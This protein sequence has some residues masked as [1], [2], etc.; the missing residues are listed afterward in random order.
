MSTRK[1]K[2]YKRDANGMRC[3]TL[4]IHEDDIKAIDK[5]ADKAQQSRSD[6]MRKAS[7]EAAGLEY[8]GPRPGA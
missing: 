3:F 4:R 7:L 1:T 5:A 2:G 8:T 6:Y